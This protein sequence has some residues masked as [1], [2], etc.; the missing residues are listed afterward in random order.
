MCW[1]ILSAMS[2][3]RWNRFHGNHL[4]TLGHIKKRRRLT[5][6]SQWHQSHWTSPCRSSIKLPGPPRHLQLGSFFPCCQLRTYHIV[7]M[8]WITIWGDGGNSCLVSSPPNTDCE[9]ASYF[10]FDPLYPET[11][12]LRPLPRRFLVSISPLWFNLLFQIIYFLGVCL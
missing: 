8:W 7:Q 4:L 11:C 1:I 9:T 5:L 6:L 10:S 2:K 3:L 12:Q